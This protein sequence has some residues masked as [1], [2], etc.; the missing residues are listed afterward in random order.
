MCLT[1]APKAVLTA[2]Q[3]EGDEHTA[4]PGGAV[5]HG[6]KKIENG[7]AIALRNSHETVRDE[8]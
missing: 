6:K 7:N 2:V 4:T 3:Q 8:E 1:V 5:L